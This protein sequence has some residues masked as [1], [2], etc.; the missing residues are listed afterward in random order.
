MSWKTMLELAT[1]LF[2]F[3]PFT[4]VSITVYSSSDFDSLSLSRIYLHLCRAFLSKMITLIISRSLSVKQNENKICAW[5]NKRREQRKKYGKRYLNFL[6]QWMCILLLPHTLTQQTEREKVK[7]RNM[8]FEIQMLVMNGL[9]FKSENK[10]SFVLFCRFDVYSLDA[11]VVRACMLYVH[12]KIYRKRC[13]LL[14]STN[15]TMAK[16]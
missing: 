16:F 13:V 6:A 5:D 15:K 3:I 8:E 10:C 1:D 2:F 12:T 7:K 4:F 14:P 11:F 9:S